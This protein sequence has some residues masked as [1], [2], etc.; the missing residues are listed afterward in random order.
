MLKYDEFI[1]ESQLDLISESILYFSP[2]LR[3]LF[4]KLSNKDGVTGEIATALADLEFDNLKDDITFIDFDKDTSYVSFTTAKNARKNL[5]EKFPEDGYENF[6]KMFDDDPKMSLSDDLYKLD[7][8]IWTKSRSPVRLGRFLNR[9]FPNKFTPAQIEEFTN[10]FKAAQEKQGEKFLLVKGDDIA[11]WYNVKNYWEDQG[12][13]GNSCMKQKPDHYF[14]I[15]TK[16][17]DKCQ[18]LCLVEENEE[19]VEKLKGR[20]LL[21]KIDTIKGSVSN[22]NPEKFEYFLDRQ[23]AID[24]SYIQKMRD[25]A[26]SQGWAY[27][28]RNSHGS[29]SGVVFNGQ[30]YSVN[31]IVEIKAEQYGKYPYMDTFRRY[32][33]FNGNLHND[34]D[35]DDHSGQYILE[36]TGG[37]Y[38]EI[39]DEEE[40]YSE[41]YDEPIPED[42]AVWSEPMQDYLWRDR[43]V[44]VTRGGRRSRGW[45]PRDYDDIVYNEWNDEYLYIDDA[46]YSEYYGYHIYADDSVSVVHSINKKTGDCNGDYYPVHQDDSDYIDFYTIRDLVWYQNIVKKAKYWEEHGG[47]LKE[48]LT[49]DTEGDWI[50]AK[51][52]ITLHRMKEPIDFVNEDED[53]ITFEWIH[54]MDAK[55]LGIEILDETKISDAWTYTDDLKEANLIKKLE[56]AIETSLNTR[57]L[58]L[59]FGEEFDKPEKDRIANLKGRLEQLDNCLVD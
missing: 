33:I 1:L 45:Y 26:S 27:K 55:L 21:W 8:E 19:G 6:Y 56:N 49:K 9:V 35:K 24:D 36:D 17:P 41:Y 31:M 43:S 37:G 48:L 44:E 32:N 30:S 7:N 50:I 40:M 13:L 57:Q 58:T 20:A 34:D 14:N 15:Y 54:E 52:K 10:K 25:Y 42:Q 29:F 2:K 12:T 5:A 59:S 3:K 23:Y 11:F 18:M 46:T 39:S 4:K 28:A 51:F 16:N 53:V 47:I 22:P 38:Q